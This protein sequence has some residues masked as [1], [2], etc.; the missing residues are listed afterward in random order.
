MPPPVSFLRTAVRNSLSSVSYATFCSLLSQCQENI[1]SGN[2]LRG[3]NH[4][5][6]SALII[7]LNQN[8]P[9]HAV[10]LLFVKL[11]HAV[12]PDN[13]CLAVKRIALCI[14]LIL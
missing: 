12:L 5:H 11:F 14:H 7:Y 10:Q 6:T 1:L 13:I 9:V 2:R 3:I 8:L 4:A